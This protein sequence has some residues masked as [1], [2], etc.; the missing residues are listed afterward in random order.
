[1]ASHLIPD[2]TTPDLGMGG[3]MGDQRADGRHRT[4]LQVAKLETVHG[5][6]LCILRNV[7][8]GGLRADVYRELAVGEPVRFELKTGR[9]VAGHVA[10]TDGTAIGVEFDSKV[11]ILAY[12]AH[13]AIEELGRRVR[14]PRVHI[15]E[16]GYLRVAD[17]EFPVDIVDA[18]QA[19][20]RVRTDRVL[21]EGGA[22]QIIADGLGERGATVRWC[23]DGC[24]GLQ[25]KQPLQFRDFAAWRTRGRPAGLLQ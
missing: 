25:F 24:V 2:R 10:W 4:V 23:R 5:D 7:S 17:R 3:P 19:G 16:R 6:E 12:L 11:P 14:A 8:A 13:Q 9:S 22:C 18:S 15:G 1:M 21:F 20:M